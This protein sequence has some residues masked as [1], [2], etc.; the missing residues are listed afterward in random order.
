M[1]APVKSC[2]RELREKYGEFSPPEYSNRFEG[3]IWCNW[4]VWAGARKHIV[5]YI[6]G[7]KSDESC[8]KNDDKIFFNGVSSLAENMV[9]YACW[10]KEVHVFAT[11]ARGVH[12]VNLMRW[13]TNSKKKRLIG[14]YYIFKH[15]EAKPPDE[16]VLGSKIPTPDPSLSTINVLLLSQKRPFIFV[17]ENDNSG[18]SPSH[19]I[20]KAAD[21]P[22]SLQAKEGNVGVEVLA[23]K[24]I[25]QVRSTLPLTSESLLL[26]HVS[27]SEENSGKQT[28]PVQL[29]EVQNS[30]VWG[31]GTEELSVGLGEPTILS[32]DPYLDT[33]T[34]EPMGP[35]GGT[36][37][38]S[39]TLSTNLVSF[40]KSDLPMGSRATKPDYH[41]LNIKFWTASHDTGASMEASTLGFKEAISVSCQ[42]SSLAHKAIGIDAIDLKAI[43][44]FT[45]EQNLIDTKVHTDY[46]L[47]SS[48]ISESGG[49]QGHPESSVFLLGDV[50]LATGW[51]TET[52]PI[53]EHI[54]KVLDVYPILESSEEI[55]SE[56]K[57]AL[58]ATVE[59]TLESDLRLRPRNERSSAEMFLD[60]L[61]EMPDASSIADLESSHLLDAEH[62][63]PLF[64]SK[65]PLAPLATAVLELFPSLLLGIV[66]MLPLPT[67]ELEPVF[68][69][70]TTRPFL[71]SFP[72]LEPTTL[73]LEHAFS[74]LMMLTYPFI[75]VRLDTIFSTP[76]MPMEAIISEEEPIDFSMAETLS[77]EAEELEAITSTME[78]GWSQTII[79]VDLELGTSATVLET[80][81][82]PTTTIKS[83][84]ASETI[85]AFSE[86]TD[87][88]FDLRIVGVDSTMPSSKSSCCQPAMDASE[89]EDTFLATVWSS[90]L[91]GPVT[92]TPYSNHHTAFLSS[93]LE[94]LF[95]STEVMTTIEQPLLERRDDD[96]LAARLGDREAHFVHLNLAFKSELFP[97]L[98]RFSVS[99]HSLLNGHFTEIPF[100]FVP[101]VSEKKKPESLTEYGFVPNI[102]STPSLPHTE[103]QSQMMQPMTLKVTKKKLQ[104]I[105][106]W[107]RLHNVEWDLAGKSLEFTVAN[108]NVAGTFNKA[109]TQKDPLDLHT[110]QTSSDFENNITSKVGHLGSHLGMLLFALF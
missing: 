26:L 22:K 9:I 2:H 109:E 59:S 5:I 97:P 68:S 89:Q 53:T 77:L 93:V 79:S 70:S 3:N 84:G 58:A 74:S 103:M 88:P 98:S 30:T 92:G 71:L 10:K 33:S 105:T 40:L 57:V 69:N 78:S 95:P 13:S 64:P 94:D 23:S 47:L 54:T 12:V 83:L 38:P 35:V 31:M 17:S 101:I 8:D 61:S 28:S 43:S 100:T 65:T 73:G 85:S 24:F 34:T 81:L 75:S 37:I 96:D 25:W 45:L 19:R 46:E 42:I 4:T 76:A 56:L 14:R 20:D 102:T 82:A 99:A 32:E 44:L 62:E 104:P 49:P 16:D 63:T 86:E 55:A 67:V 66:E 80:V 52:V 72:D 60:L 91:P 50:I 90:S 1:Y 87:P 51:E 29:I 41:A 21:L 11:Y 110:R 7:F 107:G 18:V 106:S 48:E 15:R 27:N 36:E 6:K 39:T 108:L